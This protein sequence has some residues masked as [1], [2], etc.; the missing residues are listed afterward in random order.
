MP[1][2][3]VFLDTSALLALVN[4]DDAIHVTAAAVEADLT[5][6]RIPLVTSDWVLLEFLNGASGLSL[7][8]AAARLTDRLRTSARVAL[9]P[10]TREAWDAALTL[11]RDRPDKEWSF[12]D[13]SSI[14]ICEEQGIRRVFT[15]DRHF[16]QAGLEVLL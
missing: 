13:C 15:H 9:I 8:A 6:Q 4:R 3:Q 16:A 10:A 11:Y 5:N 12:V 1:A 2:N 14:L 7:R